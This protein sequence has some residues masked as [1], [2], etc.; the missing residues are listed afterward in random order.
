MYW[1]LDITTTKKWLIPRLLLLENQIPWKTEVPWHQ[2]SKI[3][4]K[5]KH[6]YPSLTSRQTRLE[7]TRLRRPSTHRLWLVSRRRTLKLLANLLDTR[8]TGSSINGCGIAKVAVDTREQLAV[9]SL[10]T[11]HDNVALS[12]C[13]AVSAR[14]VQLA[15]CIDGEARNCYCAGSVVLDDFVGCAGCA[16]AGYLGVAVALEG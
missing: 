11:L 16:A 5:R 3:E 8:S 14:A 15:K 2:S 9:G 13:L 7:H 6:I 12:L 4:W 10:H 1:F